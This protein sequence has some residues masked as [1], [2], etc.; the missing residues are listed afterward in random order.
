[1]ARAPGKQ[2]SRDAHFASRAEP[3]RS[4]LNRL[5]TP[6]ALLPDI[7][8]TGGMMTN[9]PK[10]QP[11]S[12]TSTGAGAEAAE[13]LRAV[14]GQRGGEPGRSDK[15]AVKPPAKPSSDKMN[16]PGS[17]PLQ[18]RTTEHESGYGG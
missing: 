13:G 4:V 10:H 8:S 11:K 17:E 7:T 9:D 1:M 14:S 16:H 2:P 15:K 12:S 5:G 6:S 18:D 3:Y